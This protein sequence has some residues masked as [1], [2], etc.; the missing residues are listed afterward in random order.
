LLLVGEGIEARINGKLWRIGSLPF[1]GVDASTVPVLA[2]AGQTL[3]ALRPD[4]RVINSLH[5]LS[6]QAVRLMRQNFSWALAYNALAIPLAMTG[7]VPPWLAALGMSLSSALV[8]GNSL[9]LKTVPGS[10]SG[11]LSE[12][13]EST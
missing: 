3:I 8:I 12:P 11:V 4:F 2:E 1:C 5:E 7:Q 6:C 10:Q 13:G 9:R